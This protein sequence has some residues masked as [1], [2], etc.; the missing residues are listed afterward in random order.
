MEDADAVVVAEVEH[1]NEEGADD[2]KHE[3]FFANVFALHL[4]LEHEEIFAYN[5]ALHLCFH[6]IDQPPESLLP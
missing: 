3:E 2:S 5:F 1:T 4:S 6:P